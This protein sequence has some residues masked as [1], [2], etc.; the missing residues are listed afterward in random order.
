M[1]RK[2][3]CDQ[4]GEAQDDAPVCVQYWTEEDEDGD[5]WQDESHFCSLPCLASWATGHAL[6]E[7][8]L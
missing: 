1:T 6:D 4:C 7:P 2:Y 8:A 3:V 5:T